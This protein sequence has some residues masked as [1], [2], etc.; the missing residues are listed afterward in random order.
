MKKID[1]TI[2][3][4][5]PVKESQKGE[6]IMKEKCKLFINNIEIRNYFYDALNKLDLQCFEYVSR[7]G[8][9]PYIQFYIVNNKIQKIQ[10]P[11]YRWQNEI[12]DFLVCKSD[13]IK[14]YNVKSTKSDIYYQILDFIDFTVPTEY[15]KYKEKIKKYYEE[16]I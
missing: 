6:N 4:G 10:K 2:K 5:T 14:N 1:I 12:F 16:L 8:G 3:N 13:K 7:E 11:Y 9:I 15:L